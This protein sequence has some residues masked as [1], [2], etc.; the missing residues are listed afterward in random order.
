M[1]ISTSRGLA[2][3]PKN[4]AQ[5]PVGSSHESCWVAW[6]EVCWEPPVVPEV[7]DGVVEGGVGGGVGGVLEEGPIGFD[8]DIIAY[9][10]E[11]KYFLSLA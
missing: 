1:N 10:F 5:A 4:F 2:E 3:G 11:L 9:Q 8:D 6:A 7:V